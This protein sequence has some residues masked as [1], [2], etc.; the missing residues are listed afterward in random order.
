MRFL[1]R[2]ISCAR[3]IL[4]PTVFHEQ[5]RFTIQYKIFRALAI[6]LAI[7]LWYDCQTL[8]SHDCYKQYKAWRSWLDKYL[9]YKIPLDMSFST[10][11]ISSARIILLSTVSMFTLLRSSSA[12]IK[13]FFS[14]STEKKY[15]SIP[16]FW[17]WQYFLSRAHLLCYSHIISHLSLFFVLFNHRRSASQH[18]KVH[19]INKDKE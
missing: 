8:S 3:I 1:T 12:S 7:F 16:K 5:Y 18:S 17:K 13:Y 2:I 4:L 10:R 14:D 6:I 9:F 15:C 19:K 11:L